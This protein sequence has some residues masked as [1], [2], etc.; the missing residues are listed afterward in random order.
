MK[1]YSQLKSYLGGNTDSSVLQSADSRVHFNPP[2]LII[3]L[4][5]DAFYFLFYYFPSLL[6]SFM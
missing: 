6:L 1:V 4:A 5:L 3:I 2:I